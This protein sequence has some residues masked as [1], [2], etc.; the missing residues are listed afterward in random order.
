MESLLRLGW[1]SC[2]M[3][4]VEPAFC[5]QADV[6]LES[7]GVPGGSWLP[8]SRVLDCRTT[9]DHQPVWGVSA[10]M[11]GLVLAKHVTGH[12]GQTNLL[13]SHLSMGH[14]SRSLVVLFRCTFVNLSRASV[15]VFRQA[16]L[17]PGNTVSKQTVFLLQILLSS[18]DIQ[19]AKLSLKGLMCS[20]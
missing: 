17:S 11:M 10:E 3:T 16:R 7:S 1:L 5:S 14:Y 15:L 6:P 18:H 12:S 4:K 2:C 13:W 9:P 8:G 20:S 19:Q